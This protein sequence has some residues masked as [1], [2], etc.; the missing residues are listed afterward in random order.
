M[1]RVAIYSRTASDSPTNNIDV[2]I[3][4]CMKIIEHN[5]DWELAGIYS[6]PNTSGFTD[7]RPGFQQM[8]ND[9]ENKK[10]D[11]ILT[12]DISRLSRN[13]N[14]LFKTLEHLKNCGIRVECER[15]R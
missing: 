11:L 4:S 7:N 1:I 9:A 13:T 15:A 10:F 6:D 8:L 14:L 3:K 12:K 2:Q 5:P